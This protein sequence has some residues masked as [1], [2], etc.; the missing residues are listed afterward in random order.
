V[1]TQVVQQQSFYPGDVPV[2]RYLR[3]S[4]FLPRPL[5]AADTAIDHKKRE[6]GK[7]DVAERGQG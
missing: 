4:T 7:V 5:R 3:T 2:P 6:V 1:Y